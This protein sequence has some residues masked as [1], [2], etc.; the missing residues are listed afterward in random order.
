MMKVSKNILK[1]LSL[2]DYEC[3]DLALES[4]LVILQSRVSVCLGPE[5]PET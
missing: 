3:L 2:A 1:I 5:W 4:L